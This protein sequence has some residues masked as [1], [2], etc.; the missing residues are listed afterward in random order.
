CAVTVSEATPEDAVALPSPVTEPAPAVC[1]K[2]TTVELSLVTTL[3]LAS[4]TAAVNVLVEPE[5]TLAVPEV[6]ASLVAVPGVTVNVDVSVVRARHSVAA[7]TGGE[8]GVRRV[9]G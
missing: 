6:K 9:T 4:S 5:A 2:T 3:L 1:E 8:P 7:C